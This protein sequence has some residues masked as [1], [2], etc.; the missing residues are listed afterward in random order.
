[1]VTVNSNRKILGTDKY[2]Y[3]LK[4]FSTDTKPTAIGGVD[5]AYNSL[6]LELDTGKYFYFSEQGW[7][8]VGQAPTE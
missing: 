6:F 3:D 8:E 2:D 7:V 1:M 4:G 5:I